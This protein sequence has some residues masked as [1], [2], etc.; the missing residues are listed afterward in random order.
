MSSSQLLEVASWRLASEIMRRHQD[1][2]ALLESSQAMEHLD[3]LLLMS[4]NPRNPVDF[5]ELNRRG[6]CQIHY[7]G[8]ERPEAWSGIWQT[9]LSEED[10]RGFLKHISM[11]LQLDL[12]KKL[13]QTTEEV[14]TFRV[15]AAFLNHAVLGRVRWEAR[16]ISTRRDS[17]EVMTDGLNPFHMGCSAAATTRQGPGQ[18]PALVPTLGTGKHKGAGQS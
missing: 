16:S 1:D 5:L 18:R 14:L 8:Q 2:L 15:I 17:P 6:D 7:S 11:N 3:A 10:P 4:R 9:Y 12:G 13:P